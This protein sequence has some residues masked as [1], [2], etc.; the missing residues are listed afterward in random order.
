MWVA[1]FFFIGMA[2]FGLAGIV[3]CLMNNTFA[4]ITYA[5]TVMVS[6]LSIG[7]IIQWKKGK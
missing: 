7:G 3:H 6:F 4:W 2:I 5:V 1:L